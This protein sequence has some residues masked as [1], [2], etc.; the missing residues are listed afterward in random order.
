MMNPA[1]NK[2]DSQNI[3]LRAPNSRGSSAESTGSLFGRN[4][5]N[6]DNAVVYYRE[7]NTNITRKDFLTYYS[8]SPLTFDYN[9]ST[10][11]KEK[12]TLIN[13]LAKQLGEDCGYDSSHQFLKLFAVTNDAEFSLNL[14]KSLDINLCSVIFNKLT[15]NPDLLQAFLINKELFTKIFSII[16]DHIDNLISMEKFLKTLEK[17]PDLLK[18]LTQEEHK[19]FFHEISL[20]ENEV[21]SYIMCRLFSRNTDILNVAF[22]NKELFL[23]VFNT[24][25]QDITS[26]LS[27]SNTLLN[28][29]ELAHALSKMDNKQFTRAIFNNSQNFL[30]YVYT[31]GKDPNLLTIFLD[32]KT[33]FLHIIDNLD[34]HQFFNFGYIF[35]KNAGL[36][37]KAV[38]N[39]PAFFLQVFNNNCITIKILAFIKANSDFFFSLD[40]KPN[41]ISLIINLDKSD[42]TK[43]AVLNKLLDE[44]LPSHPAITDLSQLIK[45]SNTPISLPEWVATEDTAI[46]PILQ[47]IY[48]I[49]PERLNEAMAILNDTRL[50]PSERYGTLAIILQSIQY[51]RRYK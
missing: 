4:V 12:K 9:N 47:F 49:I 21:P 2:I 35:E 36:L 44:H 3:E 19:Q 51:T 33:L 40:L 28:C 25:Q 45:I 41:D 1:T 14:A 46:K 43:L 48:Q 32:N 27:A 6:S 22:A 31:L 26:L 10:L 20:L 24:T 42:I 18:A 50:A 13:K 37:L 38:F 39:Y 7:T 11:S 17:N 30:R 23:K 5:E 34:N 8:E 29:P 16:N 15:K